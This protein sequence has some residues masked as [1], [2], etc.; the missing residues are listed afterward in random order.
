MAFLGIKMVDFAFMVLP[1]NNLEKLNLFLFLFV[2]PN[3]SI[4]VSQGHAIKCHSKLETVTHRFRI[5]FIFHEFGLI[6]IV[7]DHYGF[8]MILVGVFVFP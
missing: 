3:S 5:F 4:L 8:S 2:F 7:R 6:P 1:L